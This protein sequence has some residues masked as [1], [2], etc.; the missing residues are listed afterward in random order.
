MTARPP[1]KVRRAVRIVAFLLLIAVFVCWILTGTLG[2][3]SVRADIRRRIHRRVSDSPSPATGVTE[4]AYD[5]VLSRPPRPQPSIPWFYI[6]SGTAPLPFVVRVDYSYVL[7]PLIGNGGRI[8]VFWF[9]GAQI[10][11]SDKVS[12]VS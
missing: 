2:T 4:V 9:F 5:P 3:N 7:A 10:E 8:Y 11:L 12:W 1:R 6:G